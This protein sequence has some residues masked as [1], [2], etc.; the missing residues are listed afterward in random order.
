MCDVCVSTRYEAM[1]R[2]LNATGRSILYS[3]EGWTP[4]AGDWGPELANMWRTGADIWPFWDNNLPSGD[5]I[6]HNL[7]ST[8]LAAPYQRVGVAFNDPDMLQPPNTLMTVRKPGLD[9]IEAASQF[10]LWAIM[11]S[12]LVLGVNWQQLADLPTLDPEYFA[13]ITNAD[14]LAIN[15]DISPQVGSDELGL[16]YAVMYC[17]LCC[18]VL[19]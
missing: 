15:Q 4:A 11:K 6:L 17:V 2:A 8:N 16:C 5:C 1:G 3:V 7:Y 10:K 19:Y 13:L 9:P 14:M 12:P 18:A